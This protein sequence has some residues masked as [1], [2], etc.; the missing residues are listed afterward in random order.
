MKTS[1]NNLYLSV[2]LASWCF[3]SAWTANKC[4][5]SPSTASLSCSVSQLGDV[6]TDSRARNMKIV[7]SGG[8]SSHHLQSVIRQNHFQHLP[9]LHKLEVEM[10]SDL[11]IQRGAFGKLEKLK[12]LKVSH[13]T[14]LSSSN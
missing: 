14:I 8:Q 7:C 4:S 13:G 10:C 2:F 12:T 9:H 5:F 1:G 3:S 11:D 6:E